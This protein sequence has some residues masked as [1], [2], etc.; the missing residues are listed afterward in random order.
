MKNGCSI[1]ASLRSGGSGAL[2]PW[3]PPPSSLAPPL[4]HR[5]SP[6]PAQHE[7]WMS[8]ATVGLSLSP[9][10]R[11]VRADEDPSLA[12]AAIDR[13]RRVFAPDVLWWWRPDARSGLGWLDLVDCAGLG[14]SQVIDFCP[15]LVAGG[16][17]ALG[18]NWHPHHSW[19]WIYSRWSLLCCSSVDLGAPSLS[20]WHGSFG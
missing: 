14:R 11:G 10:V 19:C 8:T 20:W 16:P 5:R 9:R 15:L 7:R 6:P 12:A 4:G 18:S 3:P 13:V 17:T 2:K 1:P